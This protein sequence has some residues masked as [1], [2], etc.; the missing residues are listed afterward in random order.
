MRA[1]RCSGR[2]GRDRG[3]DVSDA[4]ET[5][6]PGTAPRAATAAEPR[7]RRATVRPTLASLPTTLR[8]QVRLFCVVLGATVLIVGLLTLL[9]VPRYVATAE[10]LLLTHGGEAGTPTGPADAEALDQTELR[11]ILSREMAGAVAA[12]LHLDRD[13]GFA[14]DESG[15]LGDRIMRVLGT[16]RAAPAP[17]SGHTTRFMLDR[18][19]RGVRVEPIAGTYSLAISFASTDPQRAAQIANAYAR[20]YTAASPADRALPPSR[21]DRPGARLI[22]EAEPPLSAASPRVLANMVLAL[23][24]GAILGC[25]AAFVAEYRFTGLTSSGDI[26]TR[27]GLVHLGSVPMLASVLPHASDPLAAVVDEPLSAFAEA[28]RSI[29]LTIRQVGG[30]NTQ[31]IA[32]TSSLPNEGKTTVAGCLTRSIALA[33]EPVVLIDCDARRRDTSTLFA[34]PGVRPGLAQVLRFEATLDEALIRDA[35][36]GAWIL[37]LTGPPADLSDLLG[38]TAMAGLLEDLR[39]RFKRI[40]IDTA[41]VLPI[42]GTRALATHVDLVVM[43]ARWRATTTH[44]INAALHLLPDRDVRIGGIVLSQI[45]MRK[46]GNYG[47]EDAAFYYKQYEKYYS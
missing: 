6:Q 29:F 12:T 22:S 9:Q 46:T 17:A 42:S 32:I 36:S 11:I 3:R 31:V 33:N 26:G 39:R 4:F 18:L 28:F 5:D 45:D 30:R 8:R 20:L 47:E 21:L 19:Q 1:N 13:T 34:Q 27:L 41:P 16:R 25:V 44:A 38:G 43:V 15:R 10:V 35:P 23:L 7:A 37:P 40:V 2:P 24:I 14:D